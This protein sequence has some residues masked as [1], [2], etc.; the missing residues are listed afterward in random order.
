MCSQSGKTYLTD[1]ERRK[2]RPTI[3]YF[4]IMITGGAW[5]LQPWLGIVDAARE[6]DV[7][8]V[9]FVGRTV[10]IGRANVI[11]DLAR[12]GRLDGLII[13]NAGLVEK[14]AEAERKAFCEQYGVP[15][16]TLE[17]SL[18]GFPCVTYENY[19]G[20]Q[21]LT[22]HLIQV[23]GYRKIGFLGMLEHHE[24]FRERYRGY[25]DAMEAHGLPVDPMLA[26]PWF[27]PEQLAGGLVET[28][29]MNDYVDHAMALGMEAVIGIA[30]NIAYQVSGELEKRGIRVPKEV[31]VVGFDDNYESRTI[32]PPLTTVKAPFYEMGY[33][34]AETLIDLLAGKSVPELV[35]VPATLMVRQ[36]CGC[37]D[38]YVAAVT[39]K[40]MPAMKASLAEA[41]P[42]H[43]DVAAAM[44]QATQDG[45]MEGVQHEVES[46]LARFAAELAGE[47][48]GGFLEALGEAL[49]QSADT[50]DEL[51]KWHSILSVLRQQILSQLAPNAPETRQAEDLLQQAQVLV[52]RVAERTQM[53][54]S[55]RATEEEADLQSVSMSLLTTL[56]INTLMDTLADELPG[57]GIPS[58]YLSF[59]ENPRPYQYPDPAPEW[60]R[61]V[62]AYGPQGR[63]SLESHGR[64]FPAGQLIPDELWP[65]DRA[66]S[67]VLLSLHLQEEQIGFVLFESGSRRGGMYE[68]L[69]M[70]ISSALQ[71]ALLVKRVQER[72]AELARQQYILDTFME[73]VP[74][75]VYFKD[76]ES[77]VTR[78][79]R[80]HAIKLGFSDPAEEV[81][82]SDFDFFPEEQAQVKY[83]QEQEVIRTGQSILD[84]EES[85]GVGHWALTT[86]MPLRDENGEIVGTFGISRDITKMKEAQAALEKAYSEVER[87][88]AE[89]TAELQREQEESARLQQEVIEAQ[90][91]AIQELSTPIIPVLEG[92][93][94]M[95]L[96]GSIDTLRAK[97]VTRSLLAGIREHKAQVV[98]LDI[99]GVPIVDSGVAAYLNK[100][101]QA[102]RLKGA[103]TIVTGISEAV[104]ET[105][106][107]LGIDWSGIETLCDLRTG[108]QSVL[109]RMRVRGS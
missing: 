95:P 60:A 89:R 8:L 30:D 4:N 103:R 99:T 39:T 86:K 45:E 49:Q 50:L 82:K 44:I 100:T 73:N 10:G 97:D 67:F 46:L 13:W 57:L 18:A 88:V 24:G 77:R 105:I 47:E 2:D 16:V 84:L 52:S 85:D 87:Q 92:V 25:V 34:A 26:R 53:L 106:V 75:Q 64:R 54:R 98:I 66:C 7:N 102:A 37:R 32:T 23:H 40:S 1:T 108:L 36:S 17:G 58:C 65:Q 15:V 72:S 3:G 38:P 74:D 69:Q 94:V 27:P 93:I 71:G 104:A 81:G 96:I 20:L 90:Q 22:E 6:R 83:E 80:A 109:T 55:L 5:A 14:L 43:P 59:F 51:T 29:T 76:L 41:A 62:L 11:Y 78:A 33:T 21:R 28:H 12:G 31:A 79:N 63:A 9:T 91:R 61:L 48:T 35:N 56:D 68:T 42:I 70:Q 107:D 101:V 19:M